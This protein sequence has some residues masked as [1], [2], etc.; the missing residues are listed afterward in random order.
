[1]NFR[2]VHLD[3]H[4]SEAIDG[5]GEEFSKEN[6]QE[7]LKKGHIN[8]ITVFAKCHHGWSYHP[9]KASQMHPH[10]KFDL[11]RAQIE[12][13]HEIGVKTPV[14]ISAGLDHKYD[15][16]HPEWLCRNEDQSLLG[17]GNFLRPGYHKLCFNTPY[18]DV[19]LKQIEEVVKNYDAD[20]IFLDIV[21]PTNCHCAACTKTLLEEGKD[22]GD[23]IAVHELGERVYLN[24]TKQVEETIH[25]IKPDM[26]I[27]HNGGHIIKGRRDLAHQNT[28]LELESLPTGGW[29][30]DHFPMSA[31]Y[32]QNLGMEVLG[33]T[34]KFHTTWGEFGGYKHPNALKYEVSLAAANGA[35]C[36][37]GDQL[38]PSGKM[39]NATYTLIGEAYSYLES[40]ESWCDRVKN[41]ADIGVLS[42]ESVLVTNPDYQTFSRNY[43]ADIGCTR[44]LLEGKYLFDILDLDSDFSR[45]RV[46]ILPD[47]IRISPRFAQK[48]HD[49]VKQGG[50][51]LATG[52][53]GVDQDDRFAFDFGAEF[54]GEHPYQPTY[55]K[56][57][58]KLKSLET[59]SF[60]IYEK[61]YAV[62]GDRTE[63]WLQQPYF[64]R[65]L[66]HFCSHQ[67]TPCK[68]ENTSP[69]VTYGKDG[70]YLS[71]QVFTDYANYGE[72]FAKETIC[73]VLDQLLGEQK[74]L[75][76]DLPA[77]GIVTVQEREERQYVLHVLYAVPTRRG[78][79]TE[80]IEDLL[81]LYHTHVTL[82]LPKKVKAAYLA[83]QKTP[84]AFTHEGNRIQLEL[85]QFTCHQM[86]VLEH[87]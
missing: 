64:N 73:H 78:K 24:Y 14:Y 61:A 23:P 21:A 1:M 60:V 15:L 75:E 69:A 26:P 29:G 38:H 25:A 49:Y 84:I 80:I 62:K 53:S 58:F 42:S 54:E 77:Q 11:L 45:Y 4:T 81:P 32:V 27:F 50:K 86:I 5:I 67:H 17:A 68:G 35:K 16:E 37:I 71:W 51:I 39:D 20:G 85:E 63:G 36:S 70:A 22:P 76:T 82:H 34:G 41:V 6:F 28:H 8:S 59:A 47:L 2:Q 7:M 65:D 46:L 10:L 30:Y 56:P 66:L 9:T 44:I 31:R 79:S 18:L 33:M 52:I 74:T 3:F 13:A 43:P 87:E 57:D 19:L 48:L 83:P 55:F 40:I 72:L 12:A